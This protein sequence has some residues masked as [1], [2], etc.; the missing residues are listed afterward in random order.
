V[1]LHNVLSAVKTNLE[2]SAKREKYIRVPGYDSYH[3]SQ[4]KEMRCKFWQ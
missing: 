3:S 1:L 4:N 2:K